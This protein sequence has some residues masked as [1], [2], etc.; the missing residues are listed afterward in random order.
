VKND[1]HKYDILKDINRAH[2]RDRSSDTQGCQQR[3]RPTLFH[4]AS[5]ALTVYTC[6]P[7]LMTTGRL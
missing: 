3:D 2:H 4:W 6:I 1:I 5:R 7:T